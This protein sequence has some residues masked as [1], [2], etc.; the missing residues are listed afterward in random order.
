M[1]NRMIAAA[2]CTILFGITVNAEEKATQLVAKNNP[3]K[4]ITSVADVMGDSNIMVEAAIGFVE[5]F[6]VMG[7]CQEG[8]KARKE[9]EGKR[10]LAS[11]EIQDE[12][13]KFEKAKNDYVA[14][15]STMSDSAR[16]KEEKQLMKMERELKNLVA[17]KEEEL[18]AD[19]QIATENL[20][21]SLDASVAK[22]AQNQNLD[23]V[24]DKMTGRAMYVSD[25]FDFT[26]QA[27]KEMDK[28]YEIKL[29]QN[30]KQPE[31]TKVADNKAAAPKAPK[32]NA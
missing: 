29:A 9:I 22:L 24:I 6:A 3:Q 15:S 8:Q 30:S 1:K 4:S 31:A 26:D 13:K 21:H 14:K 10:D 23:I 12:S 28:N 32:V 17:E 7:D 16:D 5:S 11:R 25:K 27:I 19:M 20:A 2:L 18:K